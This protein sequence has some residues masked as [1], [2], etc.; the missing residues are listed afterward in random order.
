MASSP[1]QANE[2]FFGARARAV[3]LRVLLLVALLFGAAPARAD[4]PAE[5]SP[6]D[7]PLVTHVASARVPPVPADYLEEDLGWMKL[8]YSPRARELVKPLVR[9]AEEVKAHLTATF[10]HKVLER[11]EVRVAPTFEEMSQLAPEGLPPPPYASGLAYR[12]AGLVLLTLKPPEPAGEVEDLSE[13]F[14]HELAHVA[15]DDATL[16]ARSVPRWFHEG[17]AINVSGEDRFKRLHSLWTGVIGGTLAPL[18]E[19]DKKFGAERSRQ[20]VQTAYAQSADFVRFLLREGDKQR[21]M[22]LVERVRGGQAFEAALGDAYG[23]DLRKL[24][25]QWREGLSKRYT[26]LPVLAGG[27]LLWIFVIGLLGASYIKRRR[28]SK[29]TLARW[30]R[31]EADELEERRALLREG[32][33]EQRL[34]EEAGEAAIAKASLPMVEH[35]GRWYTLH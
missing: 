25:F 6:G 14:R 20:E 15:L 33:L 13:V 9:E 18:S 26:V 8:R 11:V 17:L 34:L 7:A 24:E 31:E 19:V 29:A 1:A 5:P 32:Q 16:N 12:G 30:E 22:A 23:S 10:G 35:Q 28:R 21:F 27:S 3:L 4:A 2:I